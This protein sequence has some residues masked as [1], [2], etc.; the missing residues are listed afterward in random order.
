MIRLTLSLLLTGM[1]FFAMPAQWLSNC[2]GT[3]SAIYWMKRAERAPTEFAK[4]LYLAEAIRVETSRYGRTK[5]AQAK[6]KARTARI[7]YRKRQRLP[8]SFEQRLM[9][10][11]IISNSGRRYYGRSYYGNS[12]SYYRTRTYGIPYGRYNTRYIELP[13]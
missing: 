4:Q 10:A 3:E 5:K 7:E 8:I 1:F 12:R 2:D 6:S 9:A 11:I 13:Y